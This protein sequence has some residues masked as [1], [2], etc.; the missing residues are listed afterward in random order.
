MLSEEECVTSPVQETGRLVEAIEKQLGRSLQ[1][2]VRAAFLQIPRHL[3]LDHVYRQQ[4]NRLAWDLITP[5]TTDDIYCDEALVTRL[6]DHRHPISSSS[7]PSVMASQLELLELRPGLSI[8]EIGAGTGYNAALLGQLV[9]PTGTVATIDIDPELIS[10]ATQH[11][12]EADITNVFASTGDGFNGYLERAPYDRTLATASVRS[13]P[14]P[15]MAQ[16]ALDGRLLVN[17]HLNLSS[18]F[19]LLKKVSPTRFEGRFFDLNASYMEMYNS[20][21][22]P[23]S[24]HQ[25][26][27][28]L[29]T[30]PHS[31][32]H[33]S[34]NLTELLAQPAYCLLLECLL[35]DFKKKYRAH[36]GDNEVQTY[37]IATSVPGTAIH[38]RGNHATILGN[39]EYVQARLLESMEWYE[40]LGWTLEDYT[41]SFDETQAMVHLGEK[42]FTLAI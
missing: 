13:L 40:H 28:A 17:L 31:D 12:R 37:L 30:L 38:V 36:L 32:L 3:F 33:L 41:V 8:L 23:Q 15:W 35:P 2:A 4:G 16:L 11:L 27:K 1:P 42:R 29:N 20:S 39:Q 9:G 5:P 6:D 18:L 7:Q 25:D 34:A 21:S 10:T 14:R 19:L 22:L 26:W 24:L